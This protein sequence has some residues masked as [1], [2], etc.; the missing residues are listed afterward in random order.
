MVYKLTINF[1]GMEIGI[2]KINGMELEKTSLEL[3]LAIINNTLL[4]NL[5]HTLPNPCARTS[6]V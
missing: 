4:S 1:G 3:Q 5:G 2:L 6:P